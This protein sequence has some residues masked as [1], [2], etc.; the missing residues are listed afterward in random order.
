MIV[1]KEQFYELRLDDYATPSFVSFDKPFYG[2][3]E[4]IQGFVAALEQDEECRD[5]HE[6]LISAFHAYENGNH[7]VKHHAA[8]QKIPLLIPVNVL[9]R[10]TTTLQKY[11]W[12]HMNIWDCPYDLRCEELQAE[13]AWIAVHNGY[14]RCLRA[15]FKNLELQSIVN[16]DW[17][18]F[19]DGFWGYAH[20]L[21]Y[22]EPYV[23]NRLMVTEEA[24]KTKKLALENARADDPG[25]LL[26][27]VCDEMFADG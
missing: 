1:I 19:N 17:R 12:T 4:D 21:E 8:Y 26:D 2:T 6:E 14:A 24:F 5:R 23:Y 25:L 3:M 22:D 18:V 20:M 10:R 13:Q 7:D 9:E 27:E 15:R 11:E 16:D